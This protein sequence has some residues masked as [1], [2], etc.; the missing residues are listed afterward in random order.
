VTTSVASNAMATH[1]NPL[2]FI[3]F[4]PVV[5]VCFRYDLTQ[6]VGN[7]LASPRTNQTETI[8]GKYRPQFARMM[9]LSCA[10]VNR[11]SA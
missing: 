9:V 1:T 4:S 5:F 10:K 6:G 11:S 3:C 2:D 8:K 7:H